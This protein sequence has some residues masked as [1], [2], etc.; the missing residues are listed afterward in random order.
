[1]IHSCSEK[2]YQQVVKAFSIHCSG[3]PD[4]KCPTWK[5]GFSTT[6]EVVTPDDKFTFSKL[7]IHSPHPSSQSAKA[8]F[9]LINCI[10]IGR[11]TT[12]KRYQQLG[13]AV[14][15]SHSPLLP[16]ERMCWQLM[17]PNMPVCKPAPPK[18]C[19]GRGTDSNPPATYTCTR[20]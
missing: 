14:D 5:A 19:Y 18:L 13:R 15:C 11:T 4:W 12:G 2:K 6:I 17:Y 9:F 3:L 7:K 20:Q 1:M 10:V 8:D 16:A